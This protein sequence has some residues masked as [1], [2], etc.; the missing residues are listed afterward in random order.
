MSRPEEAR[1]LPLMIAAFGD[2]H[3]L[4][5]HT[6]L[7]PASAHEVVPTLNQRLQV[8][9][10]TDVMLGPMPGRMLASTGSPSSCQYRSWHA[11]TWQL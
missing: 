10:S 2:A 4:L 3:Q 11:C 5:E 8:A 9:R 6:S 7:D 1:K